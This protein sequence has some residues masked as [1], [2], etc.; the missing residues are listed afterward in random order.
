MLIV[1]SVRLL[2]WLKN[3]FWHWSDSRRCRAKSCATAIQATLSPSESE[4]RLQTTR[5]LQVYFLILSIQ[6]FSLASSPFAIFLQSSAVLGSSAAN[7]GNVREAIKPNRR[8]LTSFFTIM[9][10]EM[11]KRFAWRKPP[12]WKTSKPYAV[13]STQAVDLF[14]FQPQLTFVTNTETICCED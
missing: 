2:W 9:L 14:T 1:V 11:L 3:P 5:R 8:A 7:T 13:A 6:A 12:Q 4:Y 10:L